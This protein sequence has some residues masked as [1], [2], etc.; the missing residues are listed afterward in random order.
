M[1]LGSMIEAV[2]VCF[3]NCH[4]TQLYINIGILAIKVVGEVT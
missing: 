2:K 3:T 1:K 4:K